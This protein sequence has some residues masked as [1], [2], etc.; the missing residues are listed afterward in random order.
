MSTDNPVTKT[1]WGMNLQMLRK[2]LIICAAM[3][4]FGYALV[5]IY[6]KICEITGL[7]SLTNKSDRGQELAKNSQVDLTRKVTVEFD[8]NARGTWLFKPKSNSL[9]VHPGELVTIVYELKNTLERPTNGQAIPSYAPKESSQYF[10]KLECFCF[11][12]QE[13][14]ASTTREFPVV[15][16]VDPNLPK[17]VNTITL[18]YTFF[19]YGPN[20]GVPQTSAPPAKAQLKPENTGSV[21]KAVL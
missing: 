16:V 15:F 13:L 10:H 20:G 21:Q 12:K 7:N 1:L 2:C 19:E 3:F 8:A 17:H 14:A 5:P 9:E 11:K 18:S 6:R 4:A